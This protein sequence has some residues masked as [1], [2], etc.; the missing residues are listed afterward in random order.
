M[1]ATV[2]VASTKL[3]PKILKT[4]DSANFLLLF[5]V[6][7]LDVKCYC[8]CA[9]MPVSANGLGISLGFTRFLNQ[10]INKFIR[11]ESV[12]RAVPLSEACVSV[13]LISLPFTARHGS[14]RAGGTVLMLVQLSW[15]I[16]RCFSNS[17]ACT[18]TRWPI[19]STD[20]RWKPIIYWLLGFVFNLSI[21]YIRTY[22]QNF[23]KL[24]LDEMVF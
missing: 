2:Y 20:R 4:S 11:S 14:W 24:R 6:L 16:Y 19:L 22:T 18:W 13:A 1:A 15:F 3:F 17:G 5:C 7:S 12:V 9:V 23:K 8:V 21:T 10:K